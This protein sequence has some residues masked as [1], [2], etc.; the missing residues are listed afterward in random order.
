MEQNKKLAEGILRQKQ[1]MI[2]FIAENVNSSGEV[3]GNI[4]LELFDRM[5]MFYGYLQ[6]CKDIGYFV[7]DEETQVY[8]TKIIEDII[9][10]GGEKSVTIFDD[11][12]LEEDYEV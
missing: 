2:N 8:Y 11:S 12:M 1:E 10:K 4:S 6:C 3:P 7:D 5:N 9:K